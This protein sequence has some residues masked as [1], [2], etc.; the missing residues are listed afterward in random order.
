MSI[1]F[2]FPV[3]ADPYDFQRWTETKIKSVLESIGY[4]DIKI[5]PMG[6]IGAVI[7]DLLF[8][9]FGKIQIK[10]LKSLSLLGLFLIKPF[11]T[12]F[13]RVVK[14]SANIITTGYFVISAK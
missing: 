11:F 8:V 12:L 14:L 13:D 1:P 5:M 3:H 7:H 6:A 9:S 10:H 2:L 4:R